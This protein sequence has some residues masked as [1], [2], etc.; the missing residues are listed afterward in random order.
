MILDEP[1][2]GLS[3]VESR[4][5]RERLLELRARGLTILIIDHDMTFLMPMCDRM[6]VLDAGRKIAEGSPQEVQR[7]P[8]VVAAYLGERFAERSLAREEPSR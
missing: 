2:A 3:T 8:D 5:L 6:V 4:Q 1:A 7:D